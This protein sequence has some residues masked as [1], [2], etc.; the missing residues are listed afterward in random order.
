MRHYQFGLD[1]F[2]FGKQLLFGQGVAMPEDAEQEC[3]SGCCS[4]EFSIQRDHHGFLQSCL[5]LI[6]HIG[7]CEFGVFF[8]V[9]VGIHGS[10]SIRLS[11]LF[12]TLRRVVRAR[13]ILTL[14]WASVCPVMS[15][16]S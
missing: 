9:E 10:V 3:H 13:K 11:I 1:G 12:M 7:W 5:M 14:T 2:Q 15:P 8:V 6:H 16:I 4:D